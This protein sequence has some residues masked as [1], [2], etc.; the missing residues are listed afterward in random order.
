MRKI[1]IITI[2]ILSFSIFAN[3]QQI[4]PSYGFVKVVDSQNKAVAEAS[5]CRDDC[6]KVSINQAYLIEKTNQKGLT[7]RGIHLYGDDYKRPISIYK[8]GYYPFFDVFQLFKFLG[9]GWKNNRDKPLKI[10]LL[11]IP[12]SKDEKKLIGN[13]QLKRELFWTIYKQDNDTLR[14]LLKLKIS[15]NLKTGELRGVPISESISAIVFAADLLNNKALAELISTGADIN[16]TK[17][18]AKNV[19][20][21]YLLAIPQTYPDSQNKEQEAKKN[22]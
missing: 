20:I 13:E 16:S 22:N 21:N 2:L 4:P 10:E 1:F 15:P 6:D 5:I 12:Q 18:S 9:Y 3:A 14:K 17:S 11:K 19:L 8:D 7:E